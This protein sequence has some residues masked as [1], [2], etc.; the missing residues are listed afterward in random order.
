MNSPSASAL[1]RQHYHAT[2]LKVRLYNWL[3]LAIFPI[4]WLAHLCASLQ[5]EVLCLGCGY[6]VLEV[7]IAARN[8][9]LR[10]LAS[11]LMASRIDTAKAMVSGLPNISFA[12]RDVTRLKL[13]QH[14]GNILFI[15]LMHHLAAGE[16]KKLLDKIWQTVRPGGSV[17]MKDVDTHPRWKY[18][19]N[20]FHDR[21]MAGP[22]LTYYPAAFYQDYFV[23][24][25]AKV[26]N[27]R[28][29]HFYSPYNHYCLIATKPLK[30]A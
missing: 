17:I 3:R 30:H 23:R 7:V 16:Q 14:Y 15:D 28:P 4:D 13:N 12:V 10:L 9:H 6:G 8:P 21:L 27:Y 25:G 2:I 24:R 1:V 18:Y 5:G 11:D 29:R 20:F 26:M 22:P 19:W